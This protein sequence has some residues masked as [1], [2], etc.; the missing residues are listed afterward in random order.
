MH[1]APPN[2]D[3]IPLVD[4]SLLVGWSYEKTLRRVLCRK[5]A[6]RRGPDGRSWL[7]SRRSVDELVKAERGG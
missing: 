2:E 3:F 7:V 1:S 4:A 5:L 6:G